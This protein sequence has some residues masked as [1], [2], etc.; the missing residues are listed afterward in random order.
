MRE[1]AHLQA[2][3]CGN[4]IGAK[5]FFVNVILPYLFLPS[6]YP[7]FLLTFLFFSFPPLPLSPRTVLGG[8]LRRARY[9]SN[10]HLPRRLR[11]PAGT[12]KRL[13]QRSVGREVRSKSDP[14]RLGAGDD[15]RG[16][17]RPVRPD[18]SAGQFRFRA[19]RRREQLGQRPLHRRRWTRRLGPRRGP[20]RGRKLRL[21]ARISVNSFSRW[22]NR[23]WNGNVAYI[24]NSWGIS[25]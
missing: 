8:D 4:Q 14:G 5:V 24:E 15:G 21:F 9:R 11:S 7:I 19:E 2:G 23:S 16:T 12:H 25:G 13:L 1:I 6:S 22:W 3:Q 20:E 10:R 18:I 17:L